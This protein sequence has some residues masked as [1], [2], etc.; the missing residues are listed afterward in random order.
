MELND[1]TK[2]EHKL[3]MILKVISSTLIENKSFDEKIIFLSRVGFS[4]NSIAEILA[5]KPATV[6]KQ[7]SNLKRK[8]QKK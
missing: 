7:K 1:L 2:I 3:D 6:R 5:V 4:D 8:N